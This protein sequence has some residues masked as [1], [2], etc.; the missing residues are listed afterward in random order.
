M[1][2]PFKQQRKAVFFCALKFTIPKIVTFLRGFVNAYG[3]DRRKGKTIG[4]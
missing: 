4:S 3:Y 2:T 1:R